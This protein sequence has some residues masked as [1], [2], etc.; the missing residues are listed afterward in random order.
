VHSRVERLEQDCA[1]RN[2]ATYQWPDVES[3]VERKRRVLDAVRRGD[4]G[5]NC[6]APPNEVQAKAAQKLEKI[7]ETLCQSQK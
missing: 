6:A 3:D 1:A 4:L 5:R 7:E 2:R